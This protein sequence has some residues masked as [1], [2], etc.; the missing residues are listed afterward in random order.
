MGTKKIL[1]IHVPNTLDNR[2]ACIATEKVLKEV[3]GVPHN[4]LKAFG[5][6]ISSNYLKTYN[7]IL[8][9]KRFNLC[10]QDQIFL[11]IVGGKKTLTSKTLSKEKAQENI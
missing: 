4:R 6:P 11:F 10:S 3:G 9:L 5:I 8:T 7:R 1:H 2:C